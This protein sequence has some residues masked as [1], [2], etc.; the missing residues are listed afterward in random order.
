MCIKSFRGLIPLPVCVWK[1]MHACLCAYICQRYS[2]THTHTHTTVARRKESAA[3]D[4]RRDT[5]DFPAQPGR[6]SRGITII[7]NITIIIMIRISLST[8]AHAQKIRD[9]ENIHGIVKLFACAGRG[10]SERKRGREYLPGLDAPDLLP[11]LSLLRRRQLGHVWGLF[12]GNSIE[13][14]L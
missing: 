14:V 9:V 1:R 2:R 12:A 3:P 7:T 10:G 4:C 5:W 8:Q 11:Q 13:C 6:N